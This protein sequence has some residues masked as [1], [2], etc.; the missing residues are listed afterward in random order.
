MNAD[1]I[2][3]LLAVSDVARDPYTVAEV[4][5]G[6]LLAGEKDAAARAHYARALGELKLFTAGARLL[7]SPA[8]GGLNSGMLPWA[9]RGRRFNAN[10]RALAMKD[11]EGARL[12]QA[13]AAGLVDFELHQAGDGNFQILDLRKPLVGGW[14]GG[15]LNHKAQQALWQFDATKTPVP[16]PIVFHGLGF[17]WLF[18]QVFATTLG[19]YV[20]YSCALH[21]IDGDPL[22]FAMLLHMHDL[23]E[24]ITHIRTHWQIR[25]SGHEALAAFEARVLGDKSLSV[26]QQVVRCALRSTAALPI[27]DVCNSLSTKRHNTRVEQIAGSAELYADKDASYWSGRFDDALAGRGPKLRVLGITSRYTTVLQHSM[28]EMKA[29]VEA[30]FGATCE[31]HLAIEP[32]DSS[33]ENPFVE[34]IETLKPDLIFQ[35]SRMR[36]ENAAIPQNVPFVCWDQDNLPCMRTAEAT[37]SLSPLTYIAGHGAVHGFTSLNWPRENCIFVHAAAATQRYHNGPVS[38]DLL[39]KHACDVS[40]VSNAAAGPEVLAAQLRERWKAHPAWLA[41]FETLIQKIH[42]DSDAG[43]TFDYVGLKFL[44]RRTANQLSVPLE[45]MPWREMTGDLNT[46]ADRCYRHTTLHWVHRWC[47]ANSKSLRLYGRG[48]EN[49]P[50][51]AACAAGI[52]QPG[53]EARAIYQ[54]TKLSLQLIEPGFIHSRALDGLAAGGFFLARFTQADG[55]GSAAIKTLYQLARYTVENGIDSDTALEEVTN[56]RVRELIEATREYYLSHEVKEPMWRSLQVWAAAPAA[57]ILFP[58]LSAITFD[59]EKSFGTLASRYLADHAARN[60]LAAEMR[61]VIREQFSYMA[62]W[63]TFLNAVQNGLRAASCQALAAGV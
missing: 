45:P 51:F 58:K 1:A 54:A 40:Y 62:R 23:Q 44:I 3:R 6:L 41:I 18:Q 56:P 11:P 2:R 15:L 4:A 42:A 17:G 22:A 29:A 26:P 39:V 7:G 8:N 12:V 31:F 10:I 16:P 14:L 52:A 60:N 21:V 20:D 24:Q 57:G 47:I 53:E 28:A 19:T 35:L 36:Y 30:E 34:L 63:R 27:E 50:T 13:A 33:L 61:Q 9:S 59:D 49:H 43:A 38:V 55:V 25:A 46:Y 48:W 37:A 5:G 32:N